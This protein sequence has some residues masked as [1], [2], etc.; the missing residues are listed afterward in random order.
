MMRDSVERPASTWPS[1]RCGPGVR[2]L[3]WSGGCTIWAGPSSG[4]GPGRCSSRSSWP[5]RPPAGA[6]LFRRH[7]AAALPANLVTGGG[8]RMTRTWRPGRAG[9]RALPGPAP[10]SRVR[11]ADRLLQPGRHERLTGGKPSHKSIDQGSDMQALIA[12]PSSSWPRARCWPSQS[13]TASQSGTA[14]STRCGHA[15][16]PRSWPPPP[17][18]RQHQRRPADRG[19]PSPACGSARPATG[20]GQPPTCSAACADAPGQ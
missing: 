10:V 16:A 1:T 14:A 13:C 3:S 9:R 18:R 15:L 19:P 12:G 20:R 2:T 8:A 7:A 17:S 6:D 5:R 11:A 4:S